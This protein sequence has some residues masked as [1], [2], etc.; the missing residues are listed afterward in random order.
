MSVCMHVHVCAY[1]CVKERAVCARMHIH[2]EVRGTPTNQNFLI[3]LGWLANQ[4]A[5]VTDSPA[6]AF[7]ALGDYTQFLDL[8]SGAC[9]PVFIYTSK[10]FTDEAIFLPNMFLYVASILLPTR[11]CLRPQ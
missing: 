8:D 3:W 5:R 11:I 4:Q 9:T 1:M 6:S 7:P 2:V 10:P